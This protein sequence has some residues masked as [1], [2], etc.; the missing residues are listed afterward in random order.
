MLYNPIHLNNNQRNVYSY[1]E[2]LLNITFN[3]T[4]QIIYE[5]ILTAAFNSFFHFYPYLFNFAI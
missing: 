3:K 1:P 5:L 4:I 2:Y